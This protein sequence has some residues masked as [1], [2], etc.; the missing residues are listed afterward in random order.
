MWLLSICT[1]TPWAFI[2][3]MQSKSDLIEQ[4]VHKELYMDGGDNIPTAEV[5]VPQPTV[6]EIL[7]QH[8]APMVALVPTVA[9]VPAPTPAP[10]LVPTLA[11]TVAQVPAPTSAPK[12]PKF[13]FSCGFKHENGTPKFCPV[14]GTKQD[15]TIVRNSSNNNNNNNNSS[16]GRIFSSARVA[17]A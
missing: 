6:V 17:P 5:A 11:P 13:C 16:G 15:L 9:Q 7:T 4:N 2:W 1:L 10:T 12:T 8:L 3:W 14:C